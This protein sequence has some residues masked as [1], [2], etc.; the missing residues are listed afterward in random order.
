MAMVYDK[1]RFP[2]EQQ[3]KLY[4]CLRD[5]GYEPAEDFQKLRDSVEVLS[6]IYEPEDQIN[7]RSK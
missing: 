4:V 6:F 2:P 1:V 3:N 7:T 5:C